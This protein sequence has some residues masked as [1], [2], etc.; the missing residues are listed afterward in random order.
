M[1][2]RSVVLKLWLTIIA[3]VLVVL[4]ILAL[5]LEQFFD[6]YLLSMQRRDLTS[7]AILVSELLQQE[8]NPIITAEIGAHVM[9]A[10]HSHYY[11]IAPPGESLAVRNYMKTLTPVE[12]AQLAQNQPVIQQGIPSFMNSPDPS[13]SLYAL[14]PVTN[15][16]GQVSAF[17]VITESKDV[18]G[19]PTHTI[20]SLIIFAVVLGTILTTGLA[21]VVS[22]NLSLPLIEMNAAAAEMARGRFAIRVRVVTQD[23]VGRLGQTFNHV[24]TELEQT[25]RALTQE[26]EEIAG[27][28][29]AMTDAV[30]AADTLG[31]PTLLNPA[32]ERRFRENRA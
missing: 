22:K 24:A 32:A 30:I 4:A 21:F 27:V 29:G 25:V 20:S 23:E 17:L 31:R 19:N 16:L 14:M 1:I 18:A 15:T 6:S 11:L 7:Q 13:T 26:K 10:M 3:L 8:P 9:T 28:L 2:K 12:Q 5:Y